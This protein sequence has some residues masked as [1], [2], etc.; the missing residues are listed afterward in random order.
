VSKLRCLIIERHAWETGAHKH[1]LQIPLK[2]ANVFFGPGTSDTT[3][4]LRIWG[5]DG[6]AT[7]KLRSTT[8][9]RLYA[10][11][12]TRRLNKF[13]GM[14][15]IPSS[16]VFFQETALAGTYDLWWQTDKSVVAA[17]FHPWFQ[18]KASQHGR[19][20]LAIIVKGTVLRPVKSV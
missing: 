4:I 19:G 1:Q 2:V 15:A 13:P 16:F 3:V 10:P 17:K 20:R 11:S 7:P 18:A 14:G 5:A 12:A 9:S 8:I 6:L